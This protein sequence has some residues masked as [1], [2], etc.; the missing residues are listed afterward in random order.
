VDLSLPSGVCSMKLQYPVPGY[1]G[2]Q[3]PAPTNAA[4]ALSIKYNTARAVSARTQTQMQTACTK[5]KKTAASADKG[6]YAQVHLVCCSSGTPAVTPHQTQRHKQLNP[7]CLLVSSSSGVPFVRCS[8]SYH[9]I[10]VEHVEQRQRQQD[11]HR[12]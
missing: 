1:Q 4:A 3:A 9:G 7:Q 10:Q 2:P 11:H 12:R 5:L 8:T 6:S